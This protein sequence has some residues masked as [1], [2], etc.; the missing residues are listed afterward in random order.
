MKYNLNLTK[1]YCAHWGL[2][3][4]LRELIANTIDE[5]GQI[6][7][8]DYEYEDNPDCGS[9]VLTT[10]SNL[11]IDAFLM[12]YSVKDSD[13]IGQYGEGL[14][15]AMLV[16]TRENYNF[17][18]V[19]GN[20]TYSFEFIK[21]EGFEQETLH[22]IVNKRNTISQGTLICIDDVPMI[23][24]KSVY[25]KADIGLIENSTGL[26]SKGLLVEP[27]F[28]VEFND[29]SYGINIPYN[30]DFNRDRNCVA[31]LSIIGKTLEQFTQPKDY[32]DWWST[33]NERDIIKGF[34]DD[35]KQA[36][37]VEVVLK[38][39]P[40]ITREALIGK[41]VILSQDFCNENNCKFFEDKYFIGPYW[42]W[43][44]AI[45]SEDDYSV[46]AA[47]RESISISEIDP[48]DEC[49]VDQ[50]IETFTAKRVRLIDQYLAQGKPVNDEL[51]GLLLS[52]MPIKTSDKKQIA[53]KLNGMGYNLDPVQVAY[54]LYKEN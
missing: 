38:R 45:T 40:D 30:I 20:K 10:Y 18:F 9:L 15:L 16:L 5:G 28:R 32:V 31:D 27:Y 35:F 4:A 25:L 46:L 14:K 34:S 22:L 3:E 48:D 23:T 11:P 53:S 43:T 44:Y 50:I 47:Y 6:E 52:L 24:Y 33:A 1:N 12:G 36:I 7:Y 39:C 37:A 41:R 17:N 54:N 29:I 8:D 21:P 19:S 51:V 42:S 49:E 13:A 2:K 26:Y